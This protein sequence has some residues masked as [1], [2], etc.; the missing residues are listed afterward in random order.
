MSSLSID[1]P[2][3]GVALTGI[4]SGV[5]GF[6]TGRKK[7]GV[8][9]SAEVAEITVIDTMRAELLRLSIRITLLEGREGRLIRHVYRL[10]GLIVG[11]GMTPPQFEIDGGA[12]T[13]VGKATPA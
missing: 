5:A 8:D 7:R 3:V 13:P 12:I 9:V 2:S 1:W 10:E 6:L 11:A 4:G